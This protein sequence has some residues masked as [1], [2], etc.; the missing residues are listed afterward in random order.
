MK[1]HLPPRQREVLRARL[2]GESR[3]SIAARLGIG[4]ATV[5]G[6]LSRCRDAFGINHDNDHYSLIREAIRYGVVTVAEF[7]GVGA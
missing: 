2:L 1:V 7:M 4:L 5:D 6:H 3:K